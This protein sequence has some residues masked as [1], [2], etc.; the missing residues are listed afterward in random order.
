MSFQTYFPI[1]DQLR[2]HQQSRLLDSLSA[3]AVKRDTLLRGGSTDC[4]GLL[5]IRTGQLRAF[6]YSEE[7]REITIFRL[8]EGDLCLFCAPCVI[9]SI[10]FEVTIQAEKDT[11]FWSIPVGV[12]QQLM[13]ESAAVANYTNELM[14]SRFSEVM[15]RMEQFMWR[16]MDR[17]VAAF[18]L[19]EAAIEGTCELRITHETIANHLGSHREVITRTLR[20]FQSAG[21]VQLSRGRVTILDQEKLEDLQA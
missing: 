15:S 7:G 19:Q 3:Q 14:A 11:E 6:V 10:Q 4:A 1:W 20:E 13:A 16:S 12:Y 8:F 17:R 9:P 5:L 18:L 2:P 21:M